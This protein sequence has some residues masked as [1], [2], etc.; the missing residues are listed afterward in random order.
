MILKKPN[1]LINICSN[2]AV[3][4][5][6]TIKEKRTPDLG[7]ALVSVSIPASAR[8]SERLRGR[9]SG[10]SAPPEL[11]LLRAMVTAS[12]WLIF[13]STASILASTEVT[14]VSILSTRSRSER[15]SSSLASSPL[16]SA[17]AAA[18]A[19]FFSSFSFWFSSFIFIYL[20]F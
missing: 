8:A 10:A 19:R 4:V 9:V 1:Y 5:F 13:S 15:Y 12:A 3:R 16:R 20:N 18:S 11:C 7:P 14:V 2:Y 6:E 17:A